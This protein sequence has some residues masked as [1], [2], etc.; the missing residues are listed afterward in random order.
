MKKLL[1]LA[2]SLSFSAPAL[3]NEE[4][5]SCVASDGSSFIA[6]LYGVHSNGTYEEPGYQFMIVGLAVFRPELGLKTYSF[7]QLVRDTE[8]MFTEESE[9]WEGKDPYAKFVL[10]ARE[11]LLGVIEISRPRGQR[12]APWSGTW[13]AG[14]AGSGLP[15]HCRHGNG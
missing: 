2:L 1:A 12:E 6:E 10:E 7:D 11:G 8:T 14:G 5:L 15:V 3:A 4:A 13:Q 9:G